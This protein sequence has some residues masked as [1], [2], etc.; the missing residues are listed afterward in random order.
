M[1]LDKPPQ[2]ANLLHGITTS[3]IRLWHTRDEL[4]IKNIRPGYL[5]YFLPMVIVL[6][7]LDQRNTYFNAMPYGSILGSNMA[8]LVYGAFCLGSFFVLVSLMKELRYTP[9]VFSGIS[10]IGFLLRI[11]R[12]SCFNTRARY[13]ER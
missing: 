7:L 12:L 5:Q 3:F 10:L 2:P 4:S 1:I 8:N 11:R 9:K 13:G 6:T